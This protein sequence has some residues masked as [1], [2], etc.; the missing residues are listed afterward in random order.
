MY[1]SW[2]SNTYTLYFDYNKP[3]SASGSITGNDITS[4]AVTYDRAVGELPAPELTGWTFKGWYDDKGNEYTKETVYRVTGNTTVYASW[5]SNTYTLYF[6]YNKPGNASGEITGNDVTSK[7]VTYDS[8]VGELP[9][10]E[11]TGWTFKGWYTK[12]GEQ[13]TPETIY[14]VSGDTTLYA[15]WEANTYTLY[16]DYNKPGNAS[17]EITGNDVTSKAVT[18]DSAVGE[19][20]V[21]EL[22]G[23]TFIG[24]YTESGEQYTSET[25]YKVVGDT[26][27]YA[28]WDEAPEIKAIDRYFTLKS[29]QS[30]KITLE[31]LLSTASASDD[32]DSP[33]D[34][35]LEILDYAARDF[36]ILT[37]RSQVTILYRATDSVGNKTMKMITVHIVDTTPKVI[38]PNTYARSI[39]E[40][41]YDKPYED[42]GLEPDSIWRTNSYYAEVLKSAMEN[43]ASIKYE[44]KYFKVLWMNIPYIDYSSMTCNHIEEIWEFTSEDIK[45]VKEFI[46]EHGFGKT[47]DPDGLKKFYETFSY[48]RKV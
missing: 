10:P 19:L 43:R 36:E 23:W 41:Y 29:A 33:E 40:K 39:S 45:K 6:D 35:K 46:N 4:K 27:L 7:D 20:P 5:E 9:V 1:A 34:I 48:C 2:E 16:F 47:K 25:V 24:W 30:G 15:N 13:Y 11:L 22:T 28:Y 32:I 12:E 8:A 38:K 44:T 14:R 3:E 31:N 37:G 42:G 17:G 18:Y 26:T 21:P